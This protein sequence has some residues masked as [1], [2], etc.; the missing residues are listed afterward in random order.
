M[1]TLSYSKQTVALSLKQ[2]LR[3]M[4]K[5]FVIDI[6]LLDPTERMSNLT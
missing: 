3:V 1:V 6:V 5:C 4:H 2:R